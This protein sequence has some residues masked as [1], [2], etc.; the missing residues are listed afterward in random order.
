MS[1]GKR[2]YKISHFQGIK[3][4]SRHFGKTFKYLYRIHLKP[5]I[6]ISYAIISTVKSNLKRFIGE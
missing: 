4:A 6:F 3:T 2:E 5:L 1:G